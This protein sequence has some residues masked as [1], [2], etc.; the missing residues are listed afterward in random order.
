MIL[1]LFGIALATPSDIAVQGLAEFTNDQGPDAGGYGVGASISLY[2]RDWLAVDAHA[3]VMPTAETT[4]VT[5][6]P[7]LRVRVTGSEDA[8]GALFLAAGGGARFPGQPLGRGTIG[9]IAEIRA[10]DSIRIRPELRYLFSKPDIPGAGQFALGVAWRPRPQ[11]VEPVEPVAAPVALL[12]KEWIKPPDAQVW[13]PHPVCEW[14]PAGEIAGVLERLKPEDRIRVVAS[15]YLPAEFTVG[16]FGPTT[17]QPA[18]DQGSLLVVGSPGDLLEVGGRQVPVAADGVVLMSV[19]QGEVHGV[20]VGG[21]RRT[22]VDAAVGVGTAV[23]VRVAPPGPIRVD[24]GKNDTAIS[25]AFGARLAEVAGAAGNWTFMVRGS[26]SPDGNAAHN[27][28]LAEARAK[29]VAEFLVASGIP[30]GRVFVAPPMV[31]REA[32]VGEERLRFAEVV[33][34]PAEGE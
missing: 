15:G 21:G 9:A 14:V 29:A 34:M 11:V 17:L 13:I 7:E 23:W 12:A 32:L 3:Q 20:V 31:Q 22:P 16:G 4:T 1:A 26:A 5:F 19:P 27:L 2:L 18:P 30:R 8:Q 24:F 10:S 25:E 28:V 33:P 6:F